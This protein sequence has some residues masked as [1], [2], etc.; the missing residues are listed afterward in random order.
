MDEQARQG[1]KRYPYLLKDVVIAH[2]DHVWSADITYI[3]LRQGFTYLVAIMGWHSRYVLSWEVSAT[4]DKEFCIRALEN[5]LML[6][7]PEIFNSDQGSQFASV[8]FTGRFT[9]TVQK[10]SPHLYTSN[11]IID[12]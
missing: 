1:H 9:G 2:P 8:E 4:L 12:T 3:R 10:I 7:S 6:S 11:R 5:S